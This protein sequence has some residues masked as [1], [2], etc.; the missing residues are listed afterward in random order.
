MTFKK[1][2]LF[3]LVCLLSLIGC[4]SRDNNMYYYIHAPNQTVI[5]LKVYNIYVD[6]SFGEADKVEI[7][8]A[9][10]QWNFALNGYIKLN[11]INWKFNMEP[12]E[13]KEGM[14][15]NGWFFLK[16]YSTSKFKPADK[17]GM[18][19]LAYVD[20]LM[21]TRLFMIR[22][23]IK[24]DDMQPI[25]LHEIGHLL[26]SEH[27]G[28]QLMYPHFSQDRFKCVDYDTIVRIAREQHLDVK[29]LNYCIKGVSDH[30]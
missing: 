3:F 19:T 26:G 18:W 2:I 27:V 28:S 25:M 29:N 6:D 20:K 21:G 1:L 15:N 13:I 23:R 17:E 5:P 11:V 12:S 7:G 10:D 9:I 30:Q 24:N 4:G 8:K 22:D 16:I 14:E